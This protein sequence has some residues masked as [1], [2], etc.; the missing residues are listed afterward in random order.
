MNYKRENSDV[1]A[2]VRVIPLSEGITVNE[3]NV[4]SFP[5]EGAGGVYSYALEYTYKINSSN[6]YTLYTQ[7]IKVSVSDPPS[8]ETA[9]EEQTAENVTEPQGEKDS[10]GKTNYL[11]IIPAAAA[12]AAVICGIAVFIIVKNKKR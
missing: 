10:D 3:G 4:L 12:A 8:T 11:W 7:P 1:S 9:T 6:S 5:A 2:D